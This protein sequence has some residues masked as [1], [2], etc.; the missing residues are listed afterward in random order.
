VLLLWSN[1]LQAPHAKLLHAYNEGIHRMVVSYNGAYVASST[2][3]Q[4][5]V[6]EL[7]SG[8]QVLQ[9]QHANLAKSG[10]EP[11]TVAASCD[12]GNASSGKH[13]FWR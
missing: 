1:I 7:P 8:R 10:V 12:E 5:L 4:V 2:S 3:S 11:T 6:H 9:L 13:S